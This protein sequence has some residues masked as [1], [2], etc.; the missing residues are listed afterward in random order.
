MK[1]IALSLVLISSLF[2]TDPDNLFDN[3]FN[4]DTEF[5]N[6]FADVKKEKKEKKSYQLTFSGFLKTRGYYF[7]KKTNY[8]NKNNS[9][10]QDDSILQID[11]KLKKDNY[12]FT[13]SLFGIVGTEHNTYN[14]DKVLEE[15]RDLNKKTPIAG[16]RELYG[17][18][19][20]DKFDI[21]IGKKIFKNGISTLYSPSDVYN[22]TLAPDPLDPYTLGVWLTEFEYYTDNSSYG[23]IFFPFISNSK[24]FSPQSR[25]ASTS[26]DKS[27]SNDFIIPKK[28]TI[29]EDKN[30]KVRG[31]FRIKTS[32]I[33]LNQGIDFIFDLGIGPSLYTVLEYTDREN[34]YLETKPYG[35]Y[36]SAGFSTTYKKLEVHGEVYYQNT[37][38]NKDDDFVSAVGGATYTLD[39]W[40]DKLG[41]NKIN[42]TLEYV[43]EFVT[44][45]Y[46][47]SKTY[48]SSKQQRAP[49]ND[50]LINVNAEINDKV[51]LNYFGNIRLAIKQN[52]D[53][54]RYQKFSTQYKVKDGIVTNFFVEFFNGDV[55]SYYGKWKNNDRIGIDIKY[56]F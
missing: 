5:D 13:A 19:T 33:F 56:Y 43:K 51:S 2:A 15:F 37:F 49:K 40:V 16:I 50:I 55:N 18:K 12:L 11:S 9:Q 28:T 1:K 14:Y 8:K 53:S 54:G 4:A 42:M 34:T 45:E 38:G 29:K 6:A 32:Q 31:L 10:L 44:D 3:S 22:Y 26:D 7:L 21:T 36:T 30:N 27:I 41:L 25:W 20:G 52:K 46:D 23:L 35:W 48:R 47:H 17:I 24:T 39:K